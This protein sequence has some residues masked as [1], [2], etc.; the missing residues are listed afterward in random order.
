[1]D[2]IPIGALISITYRSNF[3]R[4][5]TRM[6]ELGLSGGQF[7]VL[8]VLSYEQGLTQDKIAWLLLIDKGSVARAVNVLEDKGFVKRVTDESNRRA[9]QLY[10]TESGERIIPEVI[11]I[12]Q[13]MEQIIFSGFTEKEKTQIKALLLKM[14]QNS[15]EAA[16]DKNDRKWKEFPLES[17]NKVPNVILKRDLS[18]WTPKRW[19]LETIRSQQFSGNMLFPQ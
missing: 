12:D 9:V 18:I 2:N 7:S 13:E 14:A 15:Y 19:I 8:M 16:Y 10:L 11:R 4:L 1:M 6:K 17:C 3:V 5:N